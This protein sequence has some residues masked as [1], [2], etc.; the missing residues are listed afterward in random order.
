MTLCPTARK[1]LDAYGGEERW[2]NATS[3]VADV[4]ASGLLFT[5]KRRP[6]LRHAR[7]TMHVA[8]PVS[9]ITPIGNDPLITGVLHQRDVTLEDV[10]GTPLARRSD[11]REYF[12]FGR[13]LLYWDDLDMAYFAN[14]AFWNYLTFPRLLLNDDIAWTEKADGVL[15]ADFPEHIPTHS[16]RQEFF[17][18]RESGLLRQHNYNADVVTSLATAAN[19]VVEHAN[20][21]GYDFPRIRRVTPRTRTGGAMRSPVLVEITLHNFVLQPA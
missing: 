21:G 10:Q 19:T 7:I 2:R 12:P 4:S 16:R 8:E 13:R 14:Y 9:R 6:P 18:D 5:L 3:I 20:F 1:A 17:F 15:S 11:A